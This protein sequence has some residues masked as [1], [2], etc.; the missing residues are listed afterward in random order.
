MLNGIFTK[1]V[2]AATLVLSLGSTTDAAFTLIDDFNGTSIDNSLW[3]TDTGGTLPTVSG[4]SADFASS[5]DFS[6]IPALRSVN[7][8]G[9]GS[10]RVTFSSFGVSP[11]HVIGLNSNP[12]STFN[13]FDALFVRDDGGATIYD[14]GVAV[15]PNTLPGVTGVPVA[16]TFLWHPDLVEIYRDATLIYSTN[17]LSLIP[18]DPTLRFDFATYQNNSSYSIDKVEYEAL[19]AAVPAPAA[20]PSG[21]VLLGTMFASRRR[22]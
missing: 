4:G 20:L 2:L 18:N 8:F 6:V 22:K 13:A 17:S 3:V 11:N 5:A 1:T 16:F 15:V 19:A 12:G 21:L 9:Y 10:F 7:G 14:N